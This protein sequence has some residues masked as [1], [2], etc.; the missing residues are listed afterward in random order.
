MNGDSTGNRSSP[1]AR[2]N[3]EKN[4]SKKAFFKKKLYRRGGAKAL[5]L[6]ATS[7][8]EPKRTK[9]GKTGRDPVSSGA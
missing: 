1:L 5:T 2:E 7:V 4:R 6:C 3:G 9:T 8:P